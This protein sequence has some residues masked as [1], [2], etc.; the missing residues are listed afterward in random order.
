M[1]L[2]AEPIRVTAKGRVDPDVR[3]VARCGEQHAFRLVLLQPG[4]QF[5]G[6]K[7]ALDF[8]LAAIGNDSEIATRTTFGTLRREVSTGRPVANNNA[9]A[10]VSASAIRAAE[11]RHH[12]SGAV[13]GTVRCGGTATI[14]ST[15]AM[16]Q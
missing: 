7:L 14:R 5:R 2:C 16:K 11:V 1:R 6:E 13:S 9:D 4:A 3:R 15:G 8:R 12:G 10:A